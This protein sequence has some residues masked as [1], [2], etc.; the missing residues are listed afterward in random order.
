MLFE[1]AGFSLGHRGDI[2]ILVI[3]KFRSLLKHRFKSIITY[4]HDK[5]KNDLTSISC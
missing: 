3:H 5:H 2:R 1:K 4:L